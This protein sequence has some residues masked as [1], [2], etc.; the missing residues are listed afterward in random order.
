MKV[1]VNPKPHKNGADGIHQVLT[2]L[3]KYLPQI[4]VEVTENLSDAD[5]VNAHIAD[6]PRNLPA[7]VPL[8]VSNHGLYTTRDE[9]WPKWAWHLNNDVFSALHQADVVTTPSVW[10][11]ELIKRNTLI[12]PVVAHHGIDVSAW[13]PTENLGFVLWNKS[14][15]DISCDST[16]VDKLASLAKAVPFVTTFGQEATNV[17]VIG[18]QKPEDMKAYV[19]QAGIYLA[20]SRE[21][22]GPCFGLLEAMACGVPVLSWNHGGNAE[23]IVHGETGYLAELNNYDDLLS[24]LY[25]CME[26]R[27]RMGNNARQLVI[28]HYQWKDVIHD[29]EQAY[30]KAI[31]R[32]SYPVKTS[33]ILTAYNLDAYLPKAVESVLNQ[34]EKDW[35][36]IIV[37]DASTDQT[38][39]ICDRYAQQ[40]SRIK[41]THNRQNYH[42]SESRNIGARHSVGRYVLPLDADDE[43]EPN[44]IEVLTQS[45]DH[46]RTLDVACGAM[47]VLMIDTGQEFV[48]GWPPDEIS[49]LKQI[50]KHNQL[51]YGSMMRRKVWENTGG[52]RRRIRNGVEDAD[53]WTR[54]L[55]YG[56]RAA[57]VTSQPT[58]FYRIRGDSLS[59][60]EKT[61]DWTPWFV[62]SKHPE[63]TPFATEWEDKGVPVHNVLPPKV[64][65]IVPVGYGHEKLLQTCLDSLINQTFPYWEI[66]VVNDT[67]VK[68]EVDNPYMQGF[69]FVKLVQTKKRSGVAA[70]RNLGV[71]N[72][73]C[74]LIAFMDADDYAQSIWLETLYKVYQQVGG[75]VYSDWYADNGT[76]IY[77]DQARDWNAESLMTKAIG[78]ISGLYSKQDFWT[79]GGFDEKIEGWEDWDLH[80]SLLEN[81]ICGTRVSYPLFT[82]RYRAGTNREKDFSNRNNLLEYISKKHTRLYQENFLMGCSACSGGRPSATVKTGSASKSSTGGSD[83][84]LFQ[85]IGEEIGMRRVKSTVNRGH[86]YQYSKGEPLFQVYREDAHIFDDLT[87]HFKRVNVPQVS[88]TEVTIEQTVMVARDQIEK[89]SPP[90]ELDIEVVNLLK[91][92]GYYTPDQI[93]VASDASLLS[94]KGIGPS[95]LKKIRELYH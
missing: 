33:V 94:I 48:S 68:W 24:G 52:W 13:T 86:S 10:V 72:S 42:V 26:H 90:V 32:N 71:K 29:Y 50:G 8:V 76:E 70:A 85:Y 73:S 12:S 21:S 67:G 79:A 30:Q 27:I 61:T 6:I 45:L 74:D 35:E 18:R 63:L 7:D 58:L 65:V 49:Y 82:Y 16:Q 80:L 87:A 20:L 34:T 23:V 15:H 53:F 46:D 3:Y 36:L 88:T 64:S 93:A 4:G 81:C 40:D 38:A 95:R 28:D 39:E 91:E 57:K 14:R 1:Y 78:P 56:Y 51:P 66:V 62:W 47:R 9:D 11:G 55:S 43:L 37:D 17:K 31:E 69:P 54:V 84:V 59:H 41:V 5:V 83:T 92:A 25:Y 75:W 60:V 22:G 77:A 44:A 2:G 89:P 19:Q